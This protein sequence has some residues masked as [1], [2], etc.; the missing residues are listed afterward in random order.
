MKAILTT[1]LLLLLAG[2]SLALGATAD[3][4]PGQPLT[5]LVPRA[6][7]GASYQVSAAVAAAIERVT[8]VPVRV[9]TRPQNH[10][11]E[12]LDYYLSLPPNG[13]TIL[14]N[15]DLLISQFVTG[16]IDLNPARGLEPL[17][18]ARAHSQLFVRS[19]E[20]RFSDLSGLVQCA[21]HQLPT[22]RQTRPLRVAL[23][24]GRGA[25]EDQLFSALE[26]ALGFDAA[27]DSISD[28][29]KRY[30]SLLQSDADLLLEQ[31]GDVRT[32]LEHGLIKPI[33]TFR[34]ERL[35]AFRE[36]PSYADLDRPLPDLPRLRGFF[37][38]PDTPPGRIDYL[39][40]AF[41][42][43]SRTPEIQ[44]YASELY[45]SGDD[46]LVDREDITKFMKK[47][48]Q[49]FRRLIDKTPSDNPSQP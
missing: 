22:C 8:E 32:F 34:P 18:V 3:G 26:Q 45:I 17:A 42:A 39:R 24:G 6:Y 23:F 5:I 13:Y 41:A 47:F 7:G 12:A 21:R 11:L 27:E 29:A 40:R 28:P 16:V 2:Q 20:S 31:P 15:Q 35:P 19:N 25:T 38:H 48:L 30:L 46:I 36:I 14:E 10:G 37:V 1:G 43:A 49:T 9:V 44:R 4:F 33:F